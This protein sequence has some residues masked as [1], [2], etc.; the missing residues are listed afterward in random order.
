MPFFTNSENI[1]NTTGEK[2]EIIKDTKDVY[3]S[4]TQE[5]ATQIGR[6]R[7]DNY[8]SHM[9]T[10]LT[11][12]NYA[13]VLVSGLGLGVIPQWLCENKNSLVDVVEIDTEL[14]NAI[15]SMNYL[16]ENINI[17]NA[18]INSYSTPVLY[19][20]IYF[21]HWFFPGNSNYES[22]RNNLL[23]LFT[24]NKKENGVIVFPVNNE[25]F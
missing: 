3:F 22:E 16:H 20:L 2:F 6:Y 12:S 21:D 17:V 19:D 5:S 23:N 8:V 10:L 15:K 18:D 1:V 25:I 13:N 9:T 11:E 4:C 14:V 7:S 24:A